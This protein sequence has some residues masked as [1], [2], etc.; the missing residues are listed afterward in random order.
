MIS[1]KKKSGLG[2]PIT[3]RIIEA[4]DWKI[5]ILERENTEFT[6]ELPKK[7]VLIKSEREKE[8]FIKNYFKK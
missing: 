5:K 7:D 6:I 4:H 3:K 2:L 8:F 1:I